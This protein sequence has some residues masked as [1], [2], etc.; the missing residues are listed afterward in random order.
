[1]NK[2]EFKDIGYILGDN[3]VRLLSVFLTN[4]LIAKYLGVDKYGEYI[5]ITTVVALL[6]I[7]LGLISPQISLRE[8]VEK[9]SPSGF[10]VSL[11]F[12]IRLTL[13]FAIVSFVIVIFKCFSISEDS[14]LYVN[15][16]YIII[17]IFNSIAILNVYFYS[18][19][20]HRFVSIASGIVV[21]VICGL[22]LI[23]I[24]QELSL[25][26][27]LLLD[28]AGSIIYGAILLYSIRRHGV[29]FS[30]IFSCNKEVEIKQFYRVVKR[31][32]MSSFPLFLSSASLL[33]ISRFDRIL[34]EEI[35]GVED[36]GRFSMIAS[37]VT[38]S[39]MIPT[40]ISDV[41]YPKLIKLNIHNREGYNGAYLF[42]LEV[43]AVVCILMSI[44]LFLCCKFI[45]IPL[46][47][48]DFDVDEIFLLLM[49]FAV[50]P[51]GL[52]VAS[53]KWL[54]IARLE[55]VIFR[56]SLIAALISV[57]LNVMLIPH[58]GI[59][60]AALAL[61]ISYLYSSIISNALSESTRELFKLQ[62]RSFLFI[63]LW[64]RV[65]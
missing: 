28:L 5:Y 17:L 34:I 23:A 11:S 48:N 62:C 32:F 50:L 44:V 9:K 64:K 33:V 29:K 24:W 61:L 27:F 47:G 52:G 63:S 12:W 41:L 14:I 1:V 65:F 21:L 25:H 36:L 54:L 38:A 30:V 58:F 43:V 18:I 51:V 13:A 22:K 59:S 20:K 2:K 46:L 53:N 37:V 3:T 31:L 49:C 8:E 39:F 40:V 15:K 56:R 45:L 57:C 42:K 7:P 16:W 19:S 10:V 6:S 4:L 55:V 60:G 26:Q 35:T